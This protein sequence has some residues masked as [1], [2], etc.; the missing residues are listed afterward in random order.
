MKVC[1][2]CQLTKPQESFYAQRAVCKQCVI[3][4]TTERNAF[5]DKETKAKW[6]KESKTRRNKAAKDFVASLKANNPCTDCGLQYDSCCMEYD[7]VNDDKVYSISKMVGDC[8][9]IAR[10]AK[11]IAKT[12]LVCILCHRQR[13]YERSSNNYNQ[14]RLDNLDYIRSFKTGPCNECGESYQPWQMD[15]DHVDPTTKTANIAQMLNHSRKRIDDEIA[16]CVLLCAK[17][18]RIKSKDN[19]QPTLIEKPLPSEE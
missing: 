1:K 16:K 8:H 18:H 15:F 17:C 19:W 3:A 7:H 14:H 10:I 9:T 5:V 11:E 4:S 13:T 2:T 6:R 12:E